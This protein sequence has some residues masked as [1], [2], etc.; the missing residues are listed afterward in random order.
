[1]LKQL[2]VFFLSLICDLFLIGIFTPGINLLCF[3]LL[4]STIK[5]ISFEIPKNL[6]AVVAFAGAP[7]PIINLLFFLIF[8][9]FF[10][11]FL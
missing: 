3:N 2:S 6:S 9:Y 11:H 10:L 7:Y 5:S 1:M 8:L 4:S